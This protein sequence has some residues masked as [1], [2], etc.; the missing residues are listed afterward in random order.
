MWS[1]AADLLPAR[2]HVLETAC[3]FRYAG[4]ELLTF[5]GGTRVMPGKH[6]SHW[7]ERE[8]FGN[9]TVVRLKTPRIPDEETVRAVFD[10]ITTLCGIGRTQIV[11]N[12]AVVEFL[13]SLAL[14][15]LVMLN[16]KIQAAG[17]RL[18][19]CQVSVSVAETLAST[20]LDS[21][22]DSYAGE[23]EAVQAFAGPD[24]SPRLGT[25]GG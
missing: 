25:E 12:L 23:Q 4:E 11:L 10:P 17:G 6:G 15:K 14:G 7:L 21:L 22:F 18:V 19:L 3:L 13:P 24:A 9:V 8:D 5:A 2:D 1:R 20:H 16:R